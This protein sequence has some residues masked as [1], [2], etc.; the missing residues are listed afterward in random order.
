MIERIGTLSRDLLPKA[1]LDVFLETGDVQARILSAY[2]L[3]D[4][5]AI[6]AE[7]E[8]FARSF[9]RM[10]SRREVEDAGVVKKLVDLSI[11]LAPHLTLN[12]K[13]KEAAAHVSTTL[14]GLSSLLRTARLAE[15]S[16][17][18]RIPEDR[19]K[20]VDRLETLKD[21]RGT[22]E[23]ALQ[24]LISDAPWLINPEWAPVTQNQTF[25]SL[26]RDIREILREG[27]WPVY[28]IVGFS[29]D[30]QASRL[31]P[32]QSKRHGPD[33]RDQEAATQALEPGNGQD[34]QLLRQH[35]GVS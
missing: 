24:Q 17:F 15:L 21:S 12:S 14:S 13:M 25:S 32:V 30:W 8:K 29:K 4:Q 5:E 9:G 34:H 19:L 1:T 27:D 7:A 35:E 10:I 2:P 22:D 28:F 18:G 26:R 6:R 20:I 31:R 11:T 23:N 33:H 16:S 3:K